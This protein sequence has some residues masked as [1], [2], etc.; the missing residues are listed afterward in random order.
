MGNSVPTVVIDEAVTKGFQEAKDGKYRLS[1]STIAFSWVKNG[2]VLFHRFNS[3]PGDFGVYIYMTKDGKSFYLQCQ[4]ESL[5][6]MLAEE[7]EK[8]NAMNF[9]NEKMIS[10]VKSMLADSATG[11]IL[12]TERIIRESND[13]DKKILQKYNLEG[14]N[15]TLNKNTWTVNINV[16]TQKGALENWVASGT[17]YPLAIRTFSKTLLEPNGTVSGWIYV[18]D[19]KT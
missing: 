15:L 1:D 8:E 18:G 6:T 4:L 12:L 13:N 9:L 11:S 5:N 7:I 2:K 17:V 3:L 14:R 10:F 16:K 19:I